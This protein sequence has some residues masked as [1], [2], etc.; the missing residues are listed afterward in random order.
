VLT[1][2]NFEQ[3]L[4][5]LRK[6]REEEVAARPEKMLRANWDIVEKF[7]EITERKVSVLDDYGDE[8]WDELPGEIVRCL[9]KINDRGRNFQATDTY[10]YEMR[11]EDMAIS[12][13]L[14]D[15]LTAR[16]EQIFKEHHEQA[17]SKHHNETDL[18]RLTGV[19]FETYV[20]RVLSSAGYEVQGTP[21]TGDQGADLIAKKD[22]RTTI[23]QAKRHQGAVGNKAV[24]EVVSAV[25]FYEGD[26]GWVV[27]NSTFTPSAMAL[28]QKTNVKLIDGVALKKKLLS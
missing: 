4:S 24:Q 1:A 28:A 16:L 9:K 22:G 21:A 18:Q 25:R 27:T 2:A 14:R 7:L 12:T 13:D 11:R 3:G 8:H 17:K 23:I 6:Q 20:A 26:E 19:E 15:V 10:T 5:E